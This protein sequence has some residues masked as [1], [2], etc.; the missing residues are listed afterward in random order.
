MGSALIGLVG[1][2]IGIL[3]AEYFRRSNRIENYSHAVFEKRLN[4][5]ETLYIKL[6]K[7]QCA[8]TDIIENP[9]YS[10]EERLNEWSP[11]VLDLAEHLDQNKLYI[12]EDIS[13]HCMLTVV[14]VEEIYDIRNN[15][16]KKKEEQ[17]FRNNINKAISMIKVETGLR[18]ID[19]LF[20]SIT[21]AKHKSDFITEFNSAKKKYQKD[22]N[23]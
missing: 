18:K 12:D 22:K 17:L 5:Y 11:V 21:K 2:F 10:K 9:K 19:N 15:K 14:G 3:I 20:K 6:N 16:K 7:I 8:S 13:I 4:I 1:V 23:L